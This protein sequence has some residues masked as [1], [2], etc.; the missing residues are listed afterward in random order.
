MGVWQTVWDALRESK[1][2]AEYF[3]GDELLPLPPDVVDAFPE[4]GWSDCMLAITVD[5]V[6]FNCHFFGFDE[7]EFDLDPRDVKGQPHLDAILQFMTALADAS[8]RDVSLS[9]EGAHDY[10]IL[11]VQPGIQGAEDLRESEGHDE[12][13]D[14]E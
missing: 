1:F 7:I 6:I 10:P 9:E 4:E 12:E 11:R 5:G 2:K 8:S 14:E 13:E 3:R